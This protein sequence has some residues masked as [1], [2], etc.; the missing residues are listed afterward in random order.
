MRLNAVT[1]GFYDLRNLEWVGDETSPSYFSV[2]QLHG[3]IC[4]VGDKE[5]GFESLFLQDY[6]KRAEHLFVMDPRVPLPPVLFPWELM[7]SKGFVDQNKFVFRDVYPLF[8]GIWERARREV[9]GADRI[10]FVGLSMHP[11]LED[12]LAYLFNGKKS[13]ETEVII[14]NPDNPV[15]VRGNSDSHWLRRPYCSA[16]ALHEMLGRVAPDM[17]RVRVLQGGSNYS[18]G[19]FTI[20]NNFES[21]IRTQL[22]A[23]FGPPPGAGG[24]TVT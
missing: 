15:L 2:L 24:T 20:V 10:S 1:S 12:G 7:T 19:E 4:I 14:A 16:Y 11:F 22:K 21:F 23:N 9:Q 3:S 13:L 18:A 17:K 8:R 6:R 5:R